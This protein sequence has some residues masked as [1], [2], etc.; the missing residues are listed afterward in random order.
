MKAYFRKTL[1]STLTFL[2]SAV[3]CTIPGYAEE[4]LSDGDENAVVEITAEADSV[5]SDLSEELGIPA[6]ELPE[7]GASSNVCG[8]NLKW[9][10]KNGVLTI[11][12][13]G[14]MYDYNWENLPPW[15][16]EGSILQKLKTVILEEGVSS[17]GSYA[18]VDCGKLERVTLPSTLEQIGASA[19]EYCSDLDA[20]SFPAG[21]KKI[22]GSAFRYCDDL[23]EIRLPEGVEDIGTWTFE[24]CTGLKTVVI[25]YGVKAV[26]DGCFRGCSKL[27]SVTMPDS[28][29]SIGGY[30]FRGCE[31]LKSISLPRSVNTIGQYAFHT[32]G[33]SSIV[34]PTGVAMID[35]GTFFECYSLTHIEL[36]Y[37]LKTVRRGAFYDC[38]ALRTIAFTGSAADWRS[39]SV[40]R[41]NN[42]WFS[43]AK[44]SYIEPPVEEIVPSVVY[45]LADEGS[46]FLRICW[47]AVRG[48]DGYQVRWSKDAQMKKG[49][50]SASY[51]GCNNAVRGDLEVGSTYYAQVRVYKME[52]GQRVYTS[53]SGKKSITLTK[54]LEAPVSQELVIRNN[55]IRAVWKPVETAEGYQVR[56]ADNPQFKQAI[57]ASAKGKSAYSYSRSGL[58][59]GKT[60]YVTVRTFCTGS[61]GNRYY[62]R[63]SETM[64]ISY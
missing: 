26:G 44:V 54:E 55:I 3:C 18:F 9:S 61:D 10:F 22:C 53:W 11:S 48:A 31:S 14:A 63:W 12:G 39:I 28:I 34:I 57:T 33:L 37:T 4:I 38:T 32:A 24:D 19:F 13:T 15:N 64:Q 25:P 7:A 62:S 17:I 56:F 16:K 27:S 50:R 43:A 30:A 41:E 36:P 35:Y 29:S 5:V 51:S 49:V 40:D 2:L 1:I 58:A 6:E 46:G 59:R 23:T 21:L 20:V 47:R 8:K 60:W 52:K 42:N 45:R